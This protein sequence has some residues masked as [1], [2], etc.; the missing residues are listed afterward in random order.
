VRQR[1]AINLETLKWIPASP[2]AE[3]WACG[4]DCRLRNMGKG[5]AV[6]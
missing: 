4:L 2:A 5:R 3:M 1:K 6:V